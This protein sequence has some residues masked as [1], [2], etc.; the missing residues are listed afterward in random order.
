MIVSIVIV[1][2]NR[3]EKSRVGKVYKGC[4][5]MKLIVAIASCLVVCI[6]SS[7][8]AYANVQPVKNKIVYLVSP[9]RC[10]STAFTSM[11]EARGDF[12]VMMEP[13]YRFSCAEVLMQIKNK[14]L[15]SN[16][17]IKD[18]SFLVEEF[19]KQNIAFLKQDNVYVFF[20]LRDPHGM[21]LSRYGCFEKIQGPFNYDEYMYKVGYRQ[22]FS[23]FN[24]VK[25]HGFN[26][27]YII[28]ADLMSSEPVSMVQKICKVLGLEYQ[29]KALS[30]DKKTLEDSFFCNMP[31]NIVTQTWQYNLM[32]ST[33]LKPLKKGH[34]ENGQPSFN[35]ISNVEHRDACKK[36][37]EYCMSFYSAMQAEKQYLL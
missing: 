5:T 11:M 8:M 1:T 19:F 26:R 31:K 34:C 3:E 12:D 16:V 20:L 29:E 15:L 36:I 7:S 35:E 17:F 24:Q 32:N 10:M 30:W 18:I 2:K 21:I 27:P 23:I 14:S 4:K 28:D 6:F 13:S 37:Y 22:L 9:P 25:Q 33:G